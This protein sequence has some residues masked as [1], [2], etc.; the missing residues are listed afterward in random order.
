MTMSSRKRRAIPI[1]L[2]RATCRVP[3]GLTPVTAATAATITARTS[4]VSQVIPAILAQQPAKLAA[5]RELMPKLI[6]QEAELEKA[7]CGSNNAKAAEVLRA[8]AATRTEGHN[9]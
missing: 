2:V 1:M 9:Q 6:S 8:I 3:L 5:Y 7:L 4:H